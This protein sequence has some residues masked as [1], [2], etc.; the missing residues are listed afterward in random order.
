M[1]SVNDDLSL[2]S[3]ENHKP[4]EGSNGLNKTLEKDPWRK[5]H[6]PKVIIEGNFKRTLKPATPKPAQLKEHTTGKGKYLRSKPPCKCYINFDKGGF[7]ESFVVTES[8]TTHLS[9]YMF[10]KKA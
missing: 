10:K 6:R 7:E 3:K 9:K 8:A 2:P 1:E 5:K 4:N